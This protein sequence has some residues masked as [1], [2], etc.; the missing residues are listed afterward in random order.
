MNF[1]PLAPIHTYVA[2]ASI[3]IRPSLT[4]AKAKCKAVK[5]GKKISYEDFIYN[6]FVHSFVRSLDL[7]S[8]A[9]SEVVFI[10][11]LFNAPFLYIISYLFYYL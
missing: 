2:A 3:M 4:A 9:K 10:H 6:W 7:G 11:V 1:S 5:I 8:S